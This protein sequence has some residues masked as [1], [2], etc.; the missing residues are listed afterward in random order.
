M[1][2]RFFACAMALALPAL[3]LAAGAQQQS[4]SAGQQQSQPAGQP[5]NQATGQQPKPKSEKEVEALKKVQAAQ[6]A[7]NWDEEIQAINYVL[8]NFADTEYKSMLLSMAID[9]AQRKNDYAQ[10]VAFGEQAIQADPNNIDARVMLAEVIAAHTR[11]NDL[12]KAQSIKKIDDYANKALDLLKTAST[13]PPGLDAAKWPDVK[14]QWTSQAYDALGQAADLDKKYPEAI[15]D[16]KSA[17]DAQPG[18]A[19]ATA[20]LAKAYVDSKQYDD[21]IS[22]A[23]K[24]LAM[25]DAPA[26]VKQFAQQQKDAATKLK[27]AK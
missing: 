11:E 8:E 5:Q 18:N 26:V 15:Q 16:F 4:Q 3:T 23:D 9:A 22:T 14:K 25:N 6:Q 19:V 13:P 7:G 1:K 12:D 27:G 24:V 2:V 20:R 17:L 10:T 21:A